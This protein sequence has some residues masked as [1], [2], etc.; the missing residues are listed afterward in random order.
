MLQGRRGETYG[1]GHA[2]PGNAWALAAGPPLP[3]KTLLSQQEKPFSHRG[4]AV[5]KNGEGC[6]EKMKESGTRAGGRRALLSFVELASFLRKFDVRH[7]VLVE[8]GI[9]FL[10][11]CHR[12]VFI[13][14]REFSMRWFDSLH[15]L[16]CFFRPL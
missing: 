2:T 13:V 10:P 6:G 12:V 8:R 7:G 4:P 16:N 11:L 3:K 15:A 5:T 1:L 14:L 9:S